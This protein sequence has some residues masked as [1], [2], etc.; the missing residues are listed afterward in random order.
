MALILIA[1]IPISEPAV[2]CEIPTLQVSLQRTGTSCTDDVK[3]EV[4][5][6]GS[7]SYQDYS[8]DCTEGNPEVEVSPTSPQTVNCSSWNIPPK[9]TGPHMARLSWCGA[10]IEFQYGGNCDFPDR[11]TCEANETCWW[12][13]GN[14]DCKICETEEIEDCADYPTTVWGVVDG[15]CPVCIR[16]PCQVDEGPCQ[17][18]SSGLLSVS[19][20]KCDAFGANVDECF[21]YS[22]ASSCDCDPCEA[23][24]AT[25]HKCDWGAGPT[26]E[27]YIEIDL[28]DS[29]GDASSGTMEL[30][31]GATEVS[32]TVVSVSGD[33]V[34]FKFT[35]EQL[36]EIFDAGC[37]YS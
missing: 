10:S 22:V 14:N 12:D 9:Q 27:K 28:A 24:E 6:N 7:S 13:D 1:H 4:K 11:A 23:G 37:W 31:C 21:D 19:C 2:T 34:K 5:A 18:V 3:W 16:N 17:I 25:G 30:K 29:Y 20:T 35:K 26:V 32:G 15:T 36:E 33:K 8:G